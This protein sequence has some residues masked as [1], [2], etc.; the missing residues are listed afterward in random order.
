MLGPYHEFYQ[1]VLK[2]YERM[3]LAGTA[4][5]PGIRESRRIACDYRMTGADYYNRATFPD[6]IGRYAYGVDLHASKPGAE[7]FNAFWEAF[8]GSDYKPGENYGISYRSLTPAKLDNVLVSGRCVDCDR[9]M[10]SSLRTM[11]CCFITGQAVG[12]AAAMA[13]REK[14]ASTREVE[15]DALQKRLK[16]LGAFLPN[17]GNG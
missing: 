5:Q 9:V 12:V 1:K 10:L 8:K 17:C 2:G 14:R 6:E 15:I 3:E 7:N 13:A 11:L 4:Q 16:A